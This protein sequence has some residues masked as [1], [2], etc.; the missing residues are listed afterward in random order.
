MIEVTAMSIE[1][2][3]T[4]SDALQANE[5]LDPSVEVAQGSSAVEPSTATTPD[6]AAGP[7]N[8]E[9]SSTDESCGAY[10]ARKWESSQSTE[11][12]AADVNR[13]WYAY[14]KATFFSR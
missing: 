8:V 7:P 1:E 13:F 10:I 9:S 6:I 5:T 4:V 2:R 11:P 14:V 3:E 12:W